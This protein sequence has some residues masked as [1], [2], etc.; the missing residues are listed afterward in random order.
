[1]E[2]KSNLVNVTVFGAG[3]EVGRSGFEIKGEKSKILLDYGI[4]V[5]EERPAFPLS[6]SPKDLDGIIITHA[7]LDHS[8]TA[9]LFYT[10]ETPPIYMTEITKQLTDILI[11]DLLHLSAYYIPFEALELKT[12]LESCRSIAEGTYKIGEAEV[13][14]QNS[15]HIPG[16]VNALV[17]IEGKRIW[18]SGDINTIDTALLTRAEPELPELDMA[19]IESTYAMVDHLPRE[20][21]ERKLVETATEVVEGGGLALIPAFSVGRSQEILCILHKHGFKY[22]IAI[23]GMSRT[24]TRMIAECPKELRDPSLLREAMARVKWVQGE[25][26]RKKLLEKRGVVISSSGMLTGGAST[27]YMEK[28]RN[29]PKDAVILVSY[30]IPGTPGRILMDEGKYGPPG[31]LRKVKCRVEWI[32]FSSHCGKSNL[33]ELVKSLKGNPKILCVHG[34]AESCTDFAER[35]K[36]E[37]GHEAYAP[38]MGDSFKL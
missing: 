31:E 15:G 10:S 11:R 28:I 14:F 2:V 37:T 33:M 23:D 18:Y 17:E 34:E 38:T 3:R 24:A 8:G 19:I 5:K 26:D 20:E 27:R 1:M 6:T 30:Q 22:D 4:L 16:S 32:D 12:M 7:H 36:E 13:R 25:R 21:C 35:I 29:R 9:P